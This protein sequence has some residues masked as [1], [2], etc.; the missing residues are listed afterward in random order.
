MPIPYA[1]L[2]TYKAPS[3]IGSPQERYFVRLASG[4]DILL[5]SSHDKEGNEFLVQ[6]LNQAAQTTEE[7][8]TKLVPTVEQMIYGFDRHIEEMLLGNVGRVQ[9]GSTTHD[10][11]LAIR[12]HLAQQ[13]GN[14][15]PNEEDIKYHR[16][17]PTLTLGEKIKLLD[18]ALK[19][20]RDDLDPHEV[21]AGLQIQIKS[22]KANIQNFDKN[23]DSERTLQYAL[24][25]LKSAARLIQQGANTL[26]L[27]E[28]P[29]GWKFT[30]LGA[31]YPNKFY[32]TL[33]HLRSGAKQ[34]EYGDTPAAAM[35]AAI[36]HAKA[37]KVE[38]K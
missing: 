21:S 11:M 2:I 31:A 23:S 25:V 30:D 27:D 20:V 34:T 35:N 8:T 32:A 5:V 36:E 14:A 1:S 7:A 24:V 4:E 15:H 16:L 33:L 26:P 3:I 38:G 18:E 28:V 6:L 22:I 12:A 10:L 29:D 19:G 37:G 13:G 17:L 9:K